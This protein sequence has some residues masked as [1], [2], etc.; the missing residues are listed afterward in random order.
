MEIV[1]ITTNIPRGF[2]K[3][4]LNWINQVNDKPMCCSIFRR[5]F[6]WLKG[7]TQ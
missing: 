7:C 1:E 2:G 4:A 6:V 3:N 5:L